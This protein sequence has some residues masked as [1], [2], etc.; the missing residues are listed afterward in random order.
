M[1]DQRKAGDTAQPKSSGKNSNV[2]KMIDGS[3]LT[4]YLAKHGIAIRY[5]TRAM[6]AEAK[7]NDEYVPITDRSMEYIR[8]E[9]D[10]IEWENR[11]WRS[12]WERT[13]FLN[14][15]DP[16]LTE[17]L[18]TLLEWDGTPRIDEWCSTAFQI[19]QDPDNV[20]FAQWT[21][22]H[23]FLGTVKRALS[24]GYALDVTPV[25]IGDQGIGKSKHLKALFPEEMKGIFGDELNLSSNSKMMLE[26]IQGKAL[27]EISEMQGL[28]RARFDKIKAFL[29]RTTD[30]G[31]RLAYRRNPEPSPRRCVFV[32][33]CNDD[34]TG[35]L[36]NDVTGNRRWLP[37][38]LIGR[39][40]HFDTFAELKDQLWAEALHRVRNGEDPSFPED[41]KHAQA[42]AN[43]AH[44]QS[45]SIE[46]L[47][48]ANE[49]DLRDINE[50]HNDGFMIHEIAGDIGMVSHTG[51]L[52]R[53]A[54]MRIAKALK[55][56]NWR[57]ERVMLNGH[58]A[59]RWYPPVGNV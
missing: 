52:N 2:M 27:I 3:D 6:K 36:P 7:I 42:Q 32:G 47:L 33:T 59:W 38:V 35:V 53:S 58:R 13:L 8:S 12:L 40:E 5:N 51:V 10:A 29:S 48:I 56:M 9:I 43:E 23:V 57:K 25:L 49:P 50:E 44:R 26:S 24:P 19:D 14:E 54:E 30:D 18:E 16:F 45:D 11:I 28:S 1:N 37:V 17:Y 21:G 31:I 55:A 20:A 46:E 39:G 22:I 34:G 15:I 4:E 41:M